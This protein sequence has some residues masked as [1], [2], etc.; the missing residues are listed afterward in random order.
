[1]A[2]KLFLVQRDQKS[3]DVIVPLPDRRLIFPFGVRL[4]LVDSLDGPCVKKEDVERF[5]A[6]ATVEITSRAAL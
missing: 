2:S 3:G 4:P 6:Y 1:M 5:A